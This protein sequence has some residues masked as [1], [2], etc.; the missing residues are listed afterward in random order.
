MFCENKNWGQEKKIDV[1]FWGSYYPYLSS[2]TFS[3]LGA[4]VCSL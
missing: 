4:L 2:R 3:P 1:A